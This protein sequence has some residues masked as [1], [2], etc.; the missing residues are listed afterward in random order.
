M[1]RKLTA[2]VP[3]MATVIL[4]RRSRAA[5]IRDHAGFLPLCVWLASYLT[6]RSDQAT[7]VGLDQLAPAARDRVSEEAVRAVASL[8]PCAEKVARHRARQLMAECIAQL[9]AQGTDIELQD[10]DYIRDRAIVIA[11]SVID[12][13]R[14]QLAYGSDGGH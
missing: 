1:H 8:D 9:L 12:R 14:H 5:A 10:A 2:L 7:A 11:D 13:Y 6:S 3:P 4:P